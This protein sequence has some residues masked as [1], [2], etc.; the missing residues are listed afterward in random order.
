MTNYYD[1]IAKGYD[2]LHGE[3]QLKKLELIGKEIN[4]DSKLKDFIKPNYKL[5]DVGCGTGISTAFF[6]VKEKLGIDPS[7][8]LINI[9]IKNYPTCEFKVGSAENLLYKDKQFDIVFSL[10]AI[11]NFDDIDI[12]LNE[13]KRVCKK[14]G[15]FILTF[16]KK[17]VK[18]S[19]I[20]TLIRLK[21]DVVKKIE[22]DKDIIYF[23]R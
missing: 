9:A 17:S 10:T 18:H 15:H 7:F 21:F 19:Q 5:L 6:K 1:G 8:E 23:C 11:Q 16:L 12:G 4:T 2:R 20:D 13:M 14:D 22:E 3:E